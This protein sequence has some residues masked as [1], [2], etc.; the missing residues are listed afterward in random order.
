MHP[1]ASIDWYPIVKRYTTELVHI[2][3]VSPGAGEIEVARQ[4]LRLLQEDGLESSYT[5]IGL[6]AL[7]GDPAGRSNAYAFLRGKRSQTIVLLGHIDTVDTKDFGAPQA[8]ALEPN[9]RNRAMLA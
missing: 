5:A 3:S 2:R 1:H 7:A 8:F 4:V 6:D 9:A